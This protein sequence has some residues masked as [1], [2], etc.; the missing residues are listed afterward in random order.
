MAGFNNKNIGN[1]YAALLGLPNPTSPIMAVP[2]S[3]TAAGTGTSAT[4]KSA[5]I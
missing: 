2:N 4:V 3:H 5:G 1:S